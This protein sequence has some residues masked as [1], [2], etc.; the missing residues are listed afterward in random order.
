MSAGGVSSAAGKEERVVKK[1]LLLWDGEPV[2]R[3]TANEIAEMLGIS[4]ASVYA[5]NG[6]KYKVNGVYEIDNADEPLDGSKMQSEWAK[7]WMREWEEI[8]EAAQ[9]LKRKR[10]RRERRQKG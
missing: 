5:A 1:Y 2:G 4:K 3:F 7:Q 9:R 6:R 8:R 10:E